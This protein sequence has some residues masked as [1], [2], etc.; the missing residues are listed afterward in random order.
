MRHLLC[1]DITE[2]TQ[3]EKNENSSLLSIIYNLSSCIFPSKLNAFSLCAQYNTSIC[4]TKKLLKGYEWHTLSEALRVCSKLTLSYCHMSDGECLLIS[5]ALKY[6]KNLT[7]INLSH[8]AITGVGISIILSALKEAPKITYLDVSFNEIGYKESL[9]LTDFFLSNATLTSLDVSFNKI[10]RTEDSEF[11]DFVGALTRT[12]SLTH[13]DLLCNDI[14]DE[15]CCILSDVLLVNTTLASLDL[16]SNG[17]TNK[18]CRVLSKALQT[19]SV[20]TYLGISYNYIEEEGYRF[21]SEALT[22]NQGI[23]HL[24]VKDHMM[25]KENLSIIS[26]SLLRNNKIRFFHTN[27][28]HKEEKKTLDSFLSFNKGIAQM[29]LTLLC[30]YKIIKGKK[31][32][33][34]AKKRKDVL[35]LL[36]SSNRL[37]FHRVLRFIQNMDYSSEKNKFINTKL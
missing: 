3:R 11:R 21:L 15:K 10:G 14:K 37:V 17:I 25:K 5:R 35:S 18:G 9:G 7:S 26:T 8:N 2:T 22:M 23:V 28:T 24:R 33:E 20:L 13:L 30:V 32:F 12:P 6:N 4:I 29:L 34:E 1:K 19:N 16:S 36:L 27:D 31:N